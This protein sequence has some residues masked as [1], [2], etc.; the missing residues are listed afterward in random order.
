MNYLDEISDRKSK[1]RGTAVGGGV[2]SASQP[3]STITYLAYSETEGRS[4]GQV[5]KEERS[6]HNLIVWALDKR[7]GRKLKGP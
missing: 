2:N 1:S 5:K 7:C 6:S 4:Q 3:L